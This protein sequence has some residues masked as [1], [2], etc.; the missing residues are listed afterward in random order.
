[1]MKKFSIISIQTKLEC[2]RS[3]D[4][5]EARVLGNHSGAGYSEEGS[6]LKLNASPIGQSGLYHCLGW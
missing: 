1:M 2:L 6:I 5:I 3:D 4:M